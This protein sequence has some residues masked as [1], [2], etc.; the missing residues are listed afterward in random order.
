MFEKVGMSASSLMCFGKQVWYV[1]RTNVATVDTRRDYNRSDAEQL[2]KEAALGKN[3][4]KARK[5][6]EK[7]QHTCKSS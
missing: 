6:T 2:N 4:D 5:N 1:A 7:E 3:K